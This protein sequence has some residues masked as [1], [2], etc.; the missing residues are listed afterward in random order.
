MSVVGI[1]LGLFDRG[2]HSNNLLVHD[3]LA[4]WPAHLHF[5]RVTNATMSLNLFL[6]LMVLLGILSL[7]VIP[8]MAFSIALWL[9]LSF[10]LT[11][12]IILMS[13]H[14]ITGRT[15]CSY[16]F[17]TSFAKNGPTKTYFVLYI[18]CLIVIINIY[19]PILRDWISL[20]IRGQLWTI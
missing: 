5:I 11:F 16:V 13:P 7:I 3:I 20:C 18:G 17:L 10:P 15:H 2:C 12:L 8:R 4:I 1:L 19:A 9:F 6:C 14:V